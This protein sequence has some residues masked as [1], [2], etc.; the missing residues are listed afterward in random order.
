MKNGPVTCARLVEYDGQF[1]MF[2]GQGEIIDIEPA[3]RGAY[4]WVKV[5]DVGLWEDRLIEAGVIHHGCLIH[6]PKV[7]EALE[8]FCYFLDIKV[9][10][11]DR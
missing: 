2:I 9:V 6:D 7:A 10:W 3:I 4:G 11:G 5:N 1:T 8:M